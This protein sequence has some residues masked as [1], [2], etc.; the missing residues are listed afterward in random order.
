MEYVC[1]GVETLLTVVASGSFSGLRRERK[2]LCRSGSI[3]LGDIALVIFVL[4]KK[5][6]VCVGY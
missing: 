5:I 4:S 6:S 3:V 2:S 1:G